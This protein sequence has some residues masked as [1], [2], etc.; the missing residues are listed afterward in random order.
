MS[1]E[2]AVAVD[3]RN[4]NKSYFTRSKLKEQYFPVQGNRIISL[5]TLSDNLKQSISYNNGPLQLSDTVQETREGFSSKI[6]IK[7][8]FCSKVHVV[9]TLTENNKAGPKMSTSKLFLALSMQG[10][11]KVSWNQLWPVWKFLA[12]Q[13]H[14][15]RT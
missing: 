10:W 9:N 7:C 1:S 15:L 3:D 11:E 14:V 8:N 13:P 12:F 2:P 4:E 5:T 6:H